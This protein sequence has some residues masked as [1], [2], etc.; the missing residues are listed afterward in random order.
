[1]Q[2]LQIFAAFATRAKVELFC[3]LFLFL[4]C[5]FIDLQLTIAVAVFVVANLNANW[6]STNKQQLTHTIVLLTQTH[7]HRKRDTI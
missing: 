1:M 5:K 2:T 4:H 7:I 3:W 6:L